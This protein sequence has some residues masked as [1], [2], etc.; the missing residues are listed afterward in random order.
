MKKHTTK[1]VLIIVVLVI[2]ALILWRN[3]GVGFS[4]SNDLP[5]EIKA[6]FG[7]AKTYQPEG[8]NFTVVSPEKLKVTEVPIDGVENGKRIIA[9]STEGKSGF[10]VVVLPFDE[11]APLTRERIL[12]DVPD[13][14]IK[15]EKTI[16]VGNIEALS[17]ESTDESLGATAEIWFNHNGFIYEARTYLEFGKTMKEILGSWKF[18]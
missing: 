1:F 4:F 14:V 8:S 16:R 6:Q 10:E 13:M 2:G 18:K 11:T 7:E 5:A 12:Q 17:F 9:E 3:G 15:N